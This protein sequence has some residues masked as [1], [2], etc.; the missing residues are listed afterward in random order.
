MTVHFNALDPGDRELGYAY[1]E[2]HFALSM[3]DELKA[4]EWRQMYLALLARRD[5]KLQDKT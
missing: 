4:A 5:A 1:S 3:K 2:W